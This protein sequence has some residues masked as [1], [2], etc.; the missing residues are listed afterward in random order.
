MICEIYVLIISS[1]SLIYV[2]FLVNASMHLIGKAIGGGE[3]GVSQ[4]G[5]VPLLEATCK[6][7]PDKLLV[8]PST[9]AF[10][11]VMH[12]HMSEVWTNA[13]KCF[14]KKGRWNAN[15]PKRAKKNDTVATDQEVHEDGKY[16]NKSGGTTKTGT[17][18]ATGYKKWRAH[19]N[20][21]LAFR[22]NRED[23]VNQ[24]DRA[25]MNAYREKMGLTHDTHANA[26]RAGAGRRVIVDEDIES[27]AN[28]EA[29]ADDL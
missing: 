22:K 16:T 21:I 2:F 4:K 14:H 11:L 5:Y 19:R 26:L 13:I 20:Q 18:N 10:I 25:I 27:D 3:W 23:E 17:F 12:D 9:E 29:E 1:H 24:V 6:N 15:L 28:D 7:F 8:T